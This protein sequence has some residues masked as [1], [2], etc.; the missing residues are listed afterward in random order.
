MRVAWRRGKASRSRLA[1]PIMGTRR[2]WA[3]ALAVVMPTRRPVKRPGPTSTPTTEISSRSMSALRQTDWMAGT[4]ISAWRRPRAT[5][6]RASTPSWPP[7]AHPTLV[8]AVSIPRISTGSAPPGLDEGFDGVAPG[9]PAGADAAQLEPALV[10]SGVVGRIG[11]AHLQVVGGQGGGHHVAPLD[12]RDPA[13]VEQ[14]G[15]GEV[16]QLGQ[17]LEAVHVDV[18]EGQAPVVGLHEGERGAGDRFEDAEA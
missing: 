4:S 16:G 2:A 3:M 15:Q 17:V 13:A 11:Q 18:V 12:H 5:S 6:N 8:V 9:M 7:M 10:L 1:I 14:L